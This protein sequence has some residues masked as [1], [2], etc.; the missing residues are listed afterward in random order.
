M[1][2]T[3]IQVDLS[4]A[5]GVSTGPILVAA[6]DDLYYRFVSEG[7]SAPTTAVL[8]M[9]SH[10]TANEPGLTVGALTIDGTAATQAIDGFAYI[11]F[12]TTTAEAAKQGTLYIFAR[13]TQ[14]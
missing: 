3:S 4:V 11:S 14:E 8:T 7:A 13:K 9:F 2:E 10:R 1:I 5:G 6:E 12:A